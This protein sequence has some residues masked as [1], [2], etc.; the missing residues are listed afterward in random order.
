MINLFTGL[1]IIF[2]QIFKRFAKNINLT[3][4][5]RNEK[6]KQNKQSKL[7]FPVHGN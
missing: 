1:H 6:S 4:I 5:W 2:A 7:Q 3:I